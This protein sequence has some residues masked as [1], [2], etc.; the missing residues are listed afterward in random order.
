MVGKDPI[1]KIV[2]LYQSFHRFYH[3][4]QQ[5]HCKNLTDS[6]NLLCYTLYNFYFIGKVNIYFF[7]T[8]LGVYRHKF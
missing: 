4:E 7:N 2:L 5:K 8:F 1:T 3:F 6:D